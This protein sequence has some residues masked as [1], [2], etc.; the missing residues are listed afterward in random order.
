MAGQ[1]GKPLSYEEWKKKRDKRVRA[2]RARQRVRENPEAGSA[3]AEKKKAAY[4]A[5][6]HQVYRLTFPDGCVYIGTTV[7]K[8]S[9]RVGGHKYKCTAVGRRIDMG[10]VPVVEVLA[11]FPRDP[12]VYARDCPNRVDAEAFEAAQYDLVDPLLRLNLRRPVEDAA[13]QMGTMRANDIQ[14][15]VDSPELLGPVPEP[16]F[17]YEVPDAVYAEA[18]AEEAEGVPG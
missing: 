14:A 7:A 11:E 4:Y 3:A 8:L 15:F 5:R 17:P 13:I 6:P 10:Q 16:V 18:S 1:N 9:E 2:E 12:E